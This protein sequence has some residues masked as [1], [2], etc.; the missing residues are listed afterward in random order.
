MQLPKRKLP[1]LSNFDYS[2]N[3]C[4]F[5]TIC[6]H[7]KTHLFGKVVDGSVQL[8]QCGQIAQ[9]ELFTIPSH[10]SGVSLDHFV[11][12]PNHVHILLTIDH[13]AERASPFTA[14]PSINEY[15]NLSLIRSIEK[16]RASP[17][18]TI[19][20][21]V[22]SFKSGVTNKIHRIFPRMTVWQKSFYDHIIR[23]ETDY[24]TICEYIE[25]N[26]LKLELDS[27]LL[28]KMNNFLK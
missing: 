6:T 23:D 24:A 9:V 26:P 4:Y 2:Q 1:R 17:F 25:N 20:S 22:G 5:I 12:M 8:N 21:I 15:T 28:N 7:Y 16:E 14:D 27:T 3:G 10:N 13:G 19:S 18:P 11:V